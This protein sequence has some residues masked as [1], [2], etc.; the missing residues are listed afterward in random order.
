MGNPLEA[1]DGNPKTATTFWNALSSYYSVNA[2]LFTSEGL[3]ITAALLHFKLGTEA[4]DW[5][6]ECMETTLARNPIDYGT[7][8][9]FKDTF[10]K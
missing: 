3:R 2:T 8:N 9:D 10:A 1:Y 5:A 7:W 4:G 6:S